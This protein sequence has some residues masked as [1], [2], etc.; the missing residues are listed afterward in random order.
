MNTEQLNIQET[1]DEEGSYRDSLA[2]VDSS[3]KRIWIYPKKPNGKF[4]DY[5]KW[6]SYVLLLFLFGMPFI[7]V[8]GKPFMLFNI[9]ET[10]FILFGIYFSP[11]DFH[12]F[13]I[14]MLILIA[15]PELALWLP[16]QFF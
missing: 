15:F 3:G 13:V 11:Q 2:T 7:K 9:L 14:G 4:Y 1:K 10:E 6:L 8:G 5:R 16:Q 12:L